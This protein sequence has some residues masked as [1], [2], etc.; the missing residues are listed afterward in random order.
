MIDPY[1]FIVDGVKETVNIMAWN[2]MMALICPVSGSE[3]Y[4]VRDG[5]V[6]G[7]LYRWLPIY[8]VG[9]LAGDGSGYWFFY[10]HMNSQSSITVKAGDHVTKGQIVGYS[11]DGL[12]NYAAHLHFGCHKNRCRQHGLSG[13]FRYLRKMLPLI[14]GH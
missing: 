3:L 12:G 1:V 5:T 10:A 14:P 13:H 8:A 7:W 11:G 9:I 4:A 6:T 2:F